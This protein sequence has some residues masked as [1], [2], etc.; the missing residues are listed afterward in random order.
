MSGDGPAPSLL[1]CPASP[2]TPSLNASATGKGGSMEERRQVGA[3]EREKDSRAV[4]REGTFEEAG[5]ARSANNGEQRGPGAGGTS[6][7]SPSRSPPHRFLSVS[8][9]H[10]VAG[11]V[12]PCS[13]VASGLSF[14]FKP[15]GPNLAPRVS[16]LDSI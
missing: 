7:H 9:G 3:A 16:N 4:Q 12:A 8:P 2:R 5:E 15:L 11:K 10:L 13:Y 14:V 6:P 1:E